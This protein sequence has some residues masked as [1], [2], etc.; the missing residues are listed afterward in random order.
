MERSKYLIGQGILE[1]PR[2]NDKAGPRL[3]N[4]GSEEIQSAATPGVNTP[5]ST[6]TFRNNIGQRVIEKPPRSRAANSSGDKPCWKS[7]AGDH[8]RE[9]ENV[10]RRLGLPLVYTQTPL[11]SDGRTM[12]ALRNGR[13]AMREL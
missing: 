12:T 3:T 6:I 11:W 9:K 5:V 1:Q 4:M 8:L 13:D 2:T 7:A 10:R